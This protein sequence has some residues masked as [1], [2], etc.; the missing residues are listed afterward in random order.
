[1]NV[2]HNLGLRLPL[3]LLLLLRRRNPL[4]GIKVARVGILPTARLRTVVLN[5]TPYL[6]LLGLLKNNPLQH[7]LKLINVLIA[8]I[9]KIL[10]ILTSKLDAIPN[11]LL[12]SLITTDPVRRLSCTTIW[13]KEHRTTRAGMQS[14]PHLAPITIPHLA[15]LQTTIHVHIRVTAMDHATLTILNKDPRRKIVCRQFGYRNVG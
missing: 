9:P 6:S 13:V 4:L 10:P 3:N 5:P 12:I 7:H 8:L 1:M 14:N 15:N 2:L 11:L